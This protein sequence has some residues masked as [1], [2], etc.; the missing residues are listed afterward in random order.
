VAKTF[1]P[2]VVNQTWLLPPSLLDFVP[3]DHPAH[4]V[5]ELVRETLDLR[6]IFAVYSE[7]RGYPPYHPAMMT[8]LLLYSYSQGV[9]SS[10]KIAKAC[11]ERVDFMAVTGLQKP[12][13]RTVSDFRKRHLEAL[14][15]LFLQV[16]RLCR[17][18]GL[19]K[20]GHVAL[21]GTKLKANASKHKAMSYA[22]MKELEPKL[23][24]EVQQWLERA[25]REDEDDDGEH[26]LDARGD[27]LPDWVANKQ[28]RLEKLREA[29]AALEAEG[30]AEVE[31]KSAQSRSDDKAEGDR[32]S[33]DSSSE[34]KPRSN[35]VRSE[36][37]KQRRRPHADGT[38]HD[39]AQ[40]NFTDPDSRI[41][42]TGD[43]YL[44][45]YNGQIAVD[46]SSQVIVAQML[47]NHQADAPLLVPMLNRIKQ[48]NGRQAKELSADA[49]YCSE[50]NLKA[51]ARRRIRGF[52]A[53]GRLRHGRNEQ[54]G[55]WGTV[56]GTKIHQ[57]RLRL[58]RA[59]F[60]SRYRL[61]KQ[62]VEPVFGQIKSVLGFAR[63]LLRG[64]VNVSLEWAF[65]CTTHNLRK[66]LASRRPL[67]A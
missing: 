43:G 4:F 40:R 48:C 19:V 50:A 44:Q 13:F 66:L 29:K 61:R 54:T 6:E 22:R 46:A 41:L 42:F 38:P 52:V 60:R 8:A 31:R 2:W 65:I 21:D 37:S 33:A 53:V 25:A 39:K 24:A 47:C 64:L 63:F 15:G 30:K 56:V 51:L 12:D 57:M 14:A 9:F 23:A 11:Q 3:E 34:V 59:G 36:R 28:K 45:G 10:R 62:V 58:A 55:R 5:R 16:L 27:E 20:L 26:G 67:A 7:E 35:G 1:R 32:T 17:E 49:G 18:A